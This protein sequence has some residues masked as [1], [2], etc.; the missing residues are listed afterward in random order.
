MYRLL[1]EVHKKPLGTRVSGAGVLEEE[2]VREFEPVA[3]IDPLGGA[4][5]RQKAEELR[6]TNTIFTTKLGPRPS[7]D[8]PFCRGSHS[9]RPQEEIKINT[10]T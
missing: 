6:K 2:D 5:N 4:G 10:R 8:R 1:R 3:S 7:Q 9:A